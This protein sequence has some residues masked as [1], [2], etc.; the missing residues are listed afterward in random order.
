MPS[1]SD[2]SRQLLRLIPQQRRTTQRTLPNHDR[3]RRCPTA[4][5]LA[6]ICSTERTSAE[7]PLGTDGS[8]RHWEVSWSSRT[9]HAQNDATERRHF[10][11]HAAPIGMYS[12]DRPR[13]RVRG[14]LAVSTEPRVSARRMLSW[15]SGCSPGEYAP[16]TPRLRRNGSSCRS[17]ADRSSLGALSV[18]VWLRRGRGGG[19]GL[20]RQFEDTLKYGFGVEVVW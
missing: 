11:Q 7:L 8:R 18:S 9:G 17:L 16:W 5:P 13:L 1:G 19:S 6:S 3:T 2:P 12:L 15:L 4:Q 20:C 14:L 10:G